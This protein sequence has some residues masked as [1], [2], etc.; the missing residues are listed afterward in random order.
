MSGAICLAPLTP[1]SSQLVFSKVKA[2]EIL[3]RLPLEI[4]TGCKISKGKGAWGYLENVP[5]C[6]M[7]MLKDSERF[8][9]TA[10]LNWRDFQT[11]TGSDDSLKS[12]EEVLT[13]NRKN[14]KVLWI[15]STHRF[16]TK[17]NLWN[18][19]SKVLHPSQMFYKYSYSCYSNTLL[20]V[21]WKCSTA[22]DEDAERLWKIRRHCKTQLERQSNKD[23]VWW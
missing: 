1:F 16:P 8:E 6:R 18:E 22:Q 13:F 15:K 4:P 20:G 9:D 10:R 14:T 23:W 7:R 3:K 17:S 5:L 21:S 2:W 19:C 12:K 11:K